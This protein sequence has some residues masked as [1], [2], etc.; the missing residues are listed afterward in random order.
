MRAE[1]NAIVDLD[2][3]VAGGGFLRD[4]AVVF[5]TAIKETAC[6]T[7]V[8]ILVICGLGKYESRSYLLLH[9]WF[10]FDAKINGDLLFIVIIII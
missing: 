7:A 4:T 1:R 6:Q 5:G 10:L 2:T 8:R 3:A 9:C